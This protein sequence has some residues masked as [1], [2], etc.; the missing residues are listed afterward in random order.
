MVSNSSF[1][2]ATETSNTANLTIAVSTVITNRR[3]TYRVNKN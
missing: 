2:C 1:V 3:I